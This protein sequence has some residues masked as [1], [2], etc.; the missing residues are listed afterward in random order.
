MARIARE[1][2]FT[3]AENAILHVVNR[4]VRRVHL[5]GQDEFS[6]KNFDYR[7][8]WIQRRINVLASF[9]GIDL[10]AF[11]IL[12]NHVHLVL[13]QRPDL[14]ASW[15]DTEVA[16][17]WLMLCPRKRSRDGSPCPPTEGQLNSI[18]N[19]PSKL[20]EIRSRLSDASWWMRLMCQTIAQRINAEDQ[21]TG[22]VWENRFRAVRLLDEASLLACAAYVDLNPIRA[23]LAELL[24]HSDYTS[25]QLR[26]QALKQR[27]EQDC[28]QEA[29]QKAGPMPDT[30]NSIPE[31]DCVSANRPDRMLAPIHLDELNDAGK[32]QASNSAY[33]CSDR[34]FL[35][36]TTTEYIEL[37]DW[38]ARSVA[39]GKAGTTPADAPA[40][41]QRLN[42]G[43]S[44]QSWCELVKNFGKLFN[45][46]AGKPHAV[47]AFQG[48]GGK[49]RFKISPL[50]STL[51][52]A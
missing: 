30:P 51:M 22:K 7:K 34:G 27:V 44:P 1:S 41:L 3:S 14:V 19:D 2:Q 20:K 29:T 32:L 43:I 21:A 15:D 50:A 39:P 31:T 38:T 33:R 23:A 5:M 10:L 45:I 25:V 46:V 17:R 6:G 11:S 26:I 42:L 37:L 4:A 13:R 47:Q 35:N 28:L 40:I 8:L 49:K 12:S 9:F 24:E 36:M 52:T 48:V 16:R 18:R